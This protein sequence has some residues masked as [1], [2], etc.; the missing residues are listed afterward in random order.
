MVE[1][2]RLTA[3]RSTRPTPPRPPAAPPRPAARPVAPL[4][5]VAPPPAPSRPQPRQRTQ[6]VETIELVET[7]SVT[8]TQHEQPTQLVELRSLEHAAE[9]LN[10][11]ADIERR[12]MELLSAGTSEPLVAVQCGVSL[13]RVFELRRGQSSTTMV[14]RSAIGNQ[15][16]ANVAPTTNA[17]ALPSPK[18]VFSRRMRD[19][20]ECLEIAIAEYKNDPESESNYNAMN[21]FM[22]TM[23]NLYKSYQDL[24][25][26]Q[27]VAERIVKQIV[28][29]FMS[30]IVKINLSAFRSMIEDMSPTLVSEFQREQFREGLK[31][32]TRRIEESVRTEFN[33][34]VKTL[35]VVYQANLSSLFLRP[36]GSTG[37]ASL[38]EAGEPKKEAA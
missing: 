4:R 16:P 35:E 37:A 27:E 14:N 29:P 23:E 25:D 3:L 22:K 13:S 2:S 7:V 10:P 6:Q 11:I 5:P 18:E 21:G 33:R 30:G 15:L 26:P 19:F 1:N 28:Y 31:D 20:D 34:A 32:A 24:D 12:A 8:Q 9:Q 17:D 38:D 36:Q